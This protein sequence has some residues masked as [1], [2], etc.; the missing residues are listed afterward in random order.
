MARRYAYGLLSALTLWGSAFAVEVEVSAEPLYTLVFDTGPGI[1][2]TPLDT[3]AADTVY[4]VIDSGYTVWSHQWKFVSFHLPTTVAAC[5][6]LYVTVAAVN[7]SYDPSGGQTGISMDFFPHDST[8]T[9]Q[10]SYF[11]NT[12]WGHYYTY[13]TLRYGDTAVHRTYLNLDTYFRYILN[14]DYPTCRDLIMAISPTLSNDTHFVL[15][16]TLYWTTQALDAAPEPRPTSPIARI[17]VYPNPFVDSFVYDG[18]RTRFRIYDILGREIASGFADA[19]S[20]VSLNNVPAGSYFFRADGSYR[21]GVI[22]LRK[23]E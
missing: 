21:S 22:M 6:C 18:P 19:R 14:R 15:S 8:D 2:Y 11:P 23:V 17:T 4:T 16:S 7:L 20:K 13:D 9:L 1:P 10:F 3:T 5:D 12:H